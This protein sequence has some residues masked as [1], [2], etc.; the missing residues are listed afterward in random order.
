MTTT[1]WVLGVLVVGLVWLL[2][3]LVRYVL[4]RRA[5]AEADRVEAS[6][7]AAAAA[8]LARQSEADEKAQQASAARNGLFYTGAAAMVNQHFANEQRY[9]EIQ[10]YMDS[11]RRLQLAT[12]NVPTPKPR[13]PTKCGSCGGVEVVQHRG[14]CLCAF[15]RTPR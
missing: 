2:V 1:V 3:N 5:Q 12:L 7:H 11:L 9:A 13:T 14:A 10:R 15:C 4:W 6:W 8:G